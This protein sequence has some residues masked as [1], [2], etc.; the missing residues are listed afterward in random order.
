[1]GLIHFYRIPALSEAK[2]RELL[3]HITQYIF[4]VESVSTE[5]CFNVLVTESLDR[6]EISVLKWLLAET[7]EANNFSDPLWSP[8]DEGG[9]KGGYYS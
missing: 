6:R 9:I 2:E 5:F 8:L 3:R 7:F 1:M 4:S